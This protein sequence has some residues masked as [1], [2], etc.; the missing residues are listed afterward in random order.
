MLKLFYFTFV[1]TQIN[2]AT[3]RS[4]DLP[5]AQSVS[6]LYAVDLKKAE[7]DELLIEI[8]KKIKNTYDFSELKTYIEEKLSFASESGYPRVISRISP[9]DLMIQ[10]VPSQTFYKSLLNKAAERGCIES[11]TILSDICAR[12]NVYLSPIKRSGFLAKI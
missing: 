8:N 7:Q 3:N 9:E 11:V 12:D 4:Q 6:L 1:S 2:S 5:E 10:V